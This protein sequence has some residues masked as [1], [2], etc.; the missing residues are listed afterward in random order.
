[1]EQTAFLGYSIPNTT[2]PTNDAFK[3]QYPSTLFKHAMEHKSSNGKICY[4]P[5]NISVQNRK[6]RF[7]EDTK[8]AQQRF[9]DRLDISFYFQTK[10]KNSTA[11]SSLKL[12]KTY[13]H[14][15]NS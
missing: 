8:I 6:Q 14:S 1:M 12:F 15:K 10:L 5:R 11:V 4:S 13:V 9:I 7:F 3:I 2:S